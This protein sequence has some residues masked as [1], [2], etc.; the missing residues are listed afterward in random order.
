MARRRSTSKFPRVIGTPSG[1]SSG[2]PKV[3]PKRKKVKGRGPPSSFPRV[4]GTKAGSGS[5][6]PKII[7]PRV[8]RERLR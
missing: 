5:S 2:F 3:R 4:V 7:L 6:F 8:K 1:P